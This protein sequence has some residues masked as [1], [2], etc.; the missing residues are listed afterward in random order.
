MRTPQIVTNK[1]RPY[2]E[3]GLRL[4]IDKRK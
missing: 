3:R 4:F 1:R 2:V